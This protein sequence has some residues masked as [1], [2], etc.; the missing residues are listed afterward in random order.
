MVVEAGV[1][2]LLADA[3]IFPD[4]NGGFMD[5]GNYRRRVLH[6]LARDPGLP[7]LT[8]QVIRRTIA[9]LAQKWER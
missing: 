2:G 7:K 4:A 9:T 8:F 3:F 5:T 1:P 6:R